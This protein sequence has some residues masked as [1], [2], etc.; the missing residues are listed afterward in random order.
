MPE[1]AAEPA[2]ARRQS[3]IA[4]LEPQLR[5]GLGLGD[6]RRPARLVDLAQ[7][8]AVIAVLPERDPGLAPGMPASLALGLPAGPPHVVLDGTHHHTLVTV[9]AA[10][11]RS[12]HHLCFELRG[13]LPWQRLP[14]PLLDVVESRQE[15]R[16]RPLQH[17]AALRLDRS[18]PSVPAQIVDIS[19]SGLQLAVPRPLS[20]LRRWGRE[21]EL[22]VQLFPGSPVHRRRVRIQRCAPASATQTALGLRL[23]TAEP[24]ATAAW[25]TDLA[26]IAASEA[27]AAR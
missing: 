12:E 8:H 21:L 5:I 10:S 23:A 3:R 20:E 2:V 16:L 17:R 9:D 19:A 22:A 15:P 11:G 1:P 25:L 6:W 14:P 4:A 27:R 26:R 24:E 18:T 13:S 7:D